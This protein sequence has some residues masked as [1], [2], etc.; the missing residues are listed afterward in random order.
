MRS[1]A[2]AVNKEVS[3]AEQAAALAA[4]T[5]VTQAALVRNARAACASGPEVGSVN[6]YRLSC[7][8]V[9]PMKLSTDLFQ[10]VSDT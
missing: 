10:Y 3:L 2:K 4:P 6:P 8:M 5:C 7:T 9:L 1:N